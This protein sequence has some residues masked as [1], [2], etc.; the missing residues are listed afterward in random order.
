MSDTPPFDLQ[1]AHRYFAADCYNQAWDYIAKL[2]R[3]PEDDEQMLRLSL[4]SH[5]HWTQR[6]DYAPENA[7][8]AYWQTAHICSLLGRAEQAQAY[9]LL[10]LQEAHKPGVAP[11]ALGYAYETL[12]RA[13]HIAGNTQSAN[14]FLQ[15]AR[16]VLT[17]I[18]DEEDRQ[19]LASD[20]DALE[21]LVDS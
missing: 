15:Q 20:L 1:Q 19:Q 11:F 16:L 5:Y 21:K 13:A 8:I 2:D 4:A 18:Q 9:G 10:S 3:T 14:D 6:A 12:A 7:S 17:S